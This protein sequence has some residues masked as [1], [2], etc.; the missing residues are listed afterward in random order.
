MFYYP[1]IFWVTVYCQKQIE[2]TWL[3]A[4]EVWKVI[5]AEL[6]M[7]SLYL[8][9]VLHWIVAYFVTIFIFVGLFLLDVKDLVP[10]LYM[11][12]W[13]LCCISLFSIC[14]L[15]VVFYINKLIVLSKKKI[16]YMKNKYKFKISFLLKCGIC[17]FCVCKCLSYTSHRHYLVIPFN[18]FNPV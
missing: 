1:C 5:S 7:F 6:P 18:Y 15:F 3:W 11:A 16:K 14:F 8:Y 12:F 9:F 4:S 17:P 13:L 2:G 10:M